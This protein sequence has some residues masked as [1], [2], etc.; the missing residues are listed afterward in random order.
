MQALASV[1]LIGVYMSAFGRW[2]ETSFKALAGEAVAGVLAD[3][4]LEH[5][6]DVDGVWFAN[7]GMGSVGQ[8]SIRGQAALSR[9]F[10]EGHLRVGA[11]VVNVENACASASTALHGA[12]RD[13]LSGQSRMVLAL[14]LEKLYRPVKN[15]AEKARVLQG[16]SAGADMLEPERWTN[17][18]RDVAA[19][20]GARFEL[21]PERSPFMD[22][23]ALQAL[24]AMRKRGLKAEHLAAAAAKAHD[25]GAL[26]PKAQYQFRM[27]PEA[28]LADRIVSPPLTRAM[29]APVGDGAAAAILC[30]EATLRGL[31]AR[32]RARALRVRA[33]VMGGGHY[34]APDEPGLIDRIGA[35]VFSADTFTARDIDVAEVHDA[36]SYGEIHIPEALGLCPHGEAGPLALAGE[37]RPGGAMPINP[38]GGLVSRG[39][40]VGATGLAMIVELGAQLR[41]EAGARQ[42]RDPKLALAYNGG[43]SVGFDEAVGVVTVLERAA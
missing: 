9:M 18:Y 30:D 29:C 21:G 2:P 32:V 37:T 25:M 27:T 43:G 39:H 41:G 36:T 14:G 10:D 16:F 31:D 28:V 40:P 1:Y 7:S 24:W 19:N 38:S 23:Y 12:Y 42:V 17:Y 13:I 11:P 4:A 33:C 22:T 26:N 34:R 3:A 5:G 15:D 8:G 6:R 35:R 20:L